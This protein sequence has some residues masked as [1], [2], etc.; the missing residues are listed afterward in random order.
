M[1]APGSVTG[2]FPRNSGT[3]LPLA[4]PETQSEDSE[5]RA[6]TGLTWPPVCQGHAGNSHLWQARTDA[7][8]HTQADG[9]GQAQVA[10]S[11]LYGLTVEVVNQTDL[12]PV[13]IVTWGP[14]SCLL[15]KDP[16]KPAAC[17]RGVW[18]PPR[19]SAEPALPRV[20]PTGSPC[21]GSAPRRSSCW[22]PAGRRRA[23]WTERPVCSAAWPPMAG[24]TWTPCS[25]VSASPSQTSRR[26]SC[27][28]SRAPADARALPRAVGTS[29]SPLLQPVRGAQGPA[30]TAPGCSPD[31]QSSGRGLPSPGGLTLNPRPCRPHR[32]SHHLLAAL[33]KLPHLSGA[34]RV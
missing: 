24:A 10:C 12:A 14:E 21:S 11:P 34:R 6:G 25:A 1:P 20:R 3:K 15:H 19:G 18:P 16:S 32:H 28:R 2:Q 13:S 4:S 31:S 30:G 22:R 8:T 23:S 29:A 17:V 33:C 26:R 5:A 7:K 27:G 9:Q